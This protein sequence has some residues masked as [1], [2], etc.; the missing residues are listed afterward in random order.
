VGGKECWVAGAVSTLRRPERTG[1]ERRRKWE[2]G[3]ITC[4]YGNEEFEG[5]SLSSNRHKQTTRRMVFPSSLP[6]TVVSDAML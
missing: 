5:T 1:L 2:R 4:D 6:Y 3:S